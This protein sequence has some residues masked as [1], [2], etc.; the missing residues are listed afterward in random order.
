MLK[1]NAKIIKW[2]KIELNFL[3]N[4]TDF[5]KYT[6]AAE[7][8][9][10]TNK[11]QIYLTKNGDEVDSIF[12]GLRVENNRDAGRFLTEVKTELTRDDNAPYKS[13]SK[14]NFTDTRNKSAQLFT[15][16]YNINDLFK[17]NNINAT[18]SS[19]KGAFKQLQN[20]NNLPDYFLSSHHLIFKKDFYWLVYLK[21]PY[22]GKKNDNLEISKLEPNKI[23][24]FPEIKNYMDNWIN[25][26][27]SRHKK[28]VSTI[29]L[30]KEANIVFY[31]Y[32]SDK[33]ITYY[34]S[35][36]EEKN[37][38]D[39]INKTEEKKLKAEKKKK[40]K[41]LAQKKAEEEKQKKLLAQKKAEEEEKQKKLIKQKEE[42][43]NKFKEKIAKLPE[44]KDPR[45]NLPKLD[46]YKLY[47]N[48]VREF[49]KEHPDE[50]D[51]VTVAE[52][53]ASVKEILDDE[54]N[55]E[56]ENNIKKMILFT[57]QSEKF[58]S[59]DDLYIK[60]TLEVSL[61]KAPREFAKLEKQI[62][63]I[64]AFLLNN[65]S[66]KYYDEAIKLT[67][68]A[69]SVFLNPESLA[70][71]SNYSLK[72]EN[73]LKK[74]KK[75]ET[76]KNNVSKQ[77]VILENYLKENL[78]INS[79]PKI[80][81][82]IKLLRSL[83]ENED[84]EKLIKKENSAENFLSKI[85]EYKKQKEEEEKRKLLAQK[86]AEEEKQ[87]KLLAQKKAEEEKQRKLLAQ[88]KAEEKAE[89]EKKRKIL[90][91]KR[92]ELNRIKGKKIVSNYSTGKKKY[93]V[94]SET[95]FHFME[96]THNL[97]TSL[98]LLYRAYDENVQADKLKAQIA[99]NLESK[100]TQKQKLQSTRS[101][102]D[103]STVDIRSKIQD[104]SQELS[105]IGKEY[106]QAALPYAYQAYGH[107]FY[108]YHRV[109]NTIENASQSSGLEGLLMNA[110]EI[111]GLLSIL[112]DL[113]QFARNMQS[114]TKL[115]FTGAKTKKVKDKGSHSKALKELE[116]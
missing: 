74:A 58:V 104:N 1:A 91:K 23:N 41:L 79:S 94:T 42:Q 64:E 36:F 35:K 16:I 14:F 51:I 15:G 88:K 45:K 89:N 48:S 4:S 101:I 62:S 106:Y 113:P 30:K 111:V 66:S 80:I 38:Y 49:M 67:K 28:I 98:E 61:K 55:N 40:E 85:P 102:V 20:N 21:N 39:V 115:I 84:Y 12:I 71:I 34:L 44:F 65:L 108:L 82:E 29:K 19:F 50:F 63:I 13:L 11:T 24:G 95:T 86:K 52:Y 53:L 2:S 54:L 110:N 57:N 105:E 60:K 56:I 96:A 112:K 5:K 77:I 100:Y 18:L 37:L 22:L 33:D 81:D 70:Q 47:L 7:H 26:S 27:I 69:K 90:A 10:R 8:W 68:E 76:S 87:R 43:E 72:I 46:Y 3:N 114:T 25:L 75:L 116:L 93:N 9:G 59:F 31:K 97:M 99:Y 6:S 92:A 32:K 17:S 83:L 109:K 78:M 73:F 107:S 103:V